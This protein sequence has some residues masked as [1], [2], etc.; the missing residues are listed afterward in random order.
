MINVSSSDRSRMLS[1]QQFV[2]HTNQHGGA[3]MH[4]NTGKM[5]QPGEPG[6]L[7]GKEPDTSGVP[8]PTRE[9]HGDPL[10]LNETHSALMRAQILTGGASHLHLGSWKN[11]SGKVDLDAVGKYDRPTAEH[12]IRKR[13]EYA[14]W[15]NEKM[16]EIRNP[17]KKA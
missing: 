3:T 10:G 14:A 16:E 9:A 17:D 6:V 1:L 13:D 2:D 8:V 15:D 4:A 11:D 7:V 5:L 12:L